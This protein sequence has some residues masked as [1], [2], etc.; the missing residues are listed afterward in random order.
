MALT[1]TAMAA[2]T[3]VAP[4]PSV[5]I[6]MICAGPAHTRAVLASTHPRLKWRVMRQR[7]DAEIGR[8]Q[9]Q[10]QH[11]R[12]D[13]AHAP[14]ERAHGTLPFRGVERRKGQGPPD[15]VSR[16]GIGL[17]KGPCVKRSAGRPAIRSGRG[18]SK[19]RS[20]GGARSKQRGEN[21]ARMCWSR[22]GST[23]GTPIISGRVSPRVEPGGI[24][25]LF[26]GP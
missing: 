16:G 8:E 5:E 22:G 4:E 9:H 7:A 12:G 15:H 17:A 19:R 6:R 1:V 3:T 14:C 13:R 23:E 20:T 26:R 18:A 2:C 11:R 24:G 21:L 10:R 25:Y